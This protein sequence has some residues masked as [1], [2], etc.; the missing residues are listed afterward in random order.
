[1]GR[2]NLTPEATLVVTAAVGSD[3]TNDPFGGQQQHGATTLGFTPSDGFSLVARARVRHPRT[4]FDAAVLAVW[5]DRDHWAKLCF[6]FS[7]QGRAMVVSVVTN[8]YSDDCNSAVVADAQVYL[9]V[10]RI[11]QGWAFH[12]SGDGLEWNFVRVFRLAFN[13]PFIVGFMAQAPN[14]ET[15]VAEFDLIEYSTVVPTDL[16][17]GT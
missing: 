10:T 9:R 15:C 8:D 6:E 3:W 13:G 16:R 2:A 12:S 4:T 7:P 17:D 14:G 1:M 11:G 5:G